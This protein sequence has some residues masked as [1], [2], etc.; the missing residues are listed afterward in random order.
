MTYITTNITGILPYFYAQ[1]ISLIAVM[2]YRTPEI[3][4]FSYMLLFSH[5]PP[6]ASFCKLIL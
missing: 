4:S 1:T 3:F 5:F 6:S 2:I